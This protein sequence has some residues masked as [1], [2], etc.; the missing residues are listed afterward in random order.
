MLRRGKNHLSDFLKKWGW[1]YGHDARFSK[2]LCSKLKLQ[3][4]E[5]WFCRWKN[6]DKKDIY[7]FLSLENP[8]FFASTFLL[9]K[10]KTWKRFFVTSSESSQNHAEKQFM[11]PKTTVIWLFSEIRCY[12]VTGWFD[13]KI[14]VFQQTFICKGLLHP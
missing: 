7:I 4:T 10:E 11:P 14:G 5:T 13:W 3:K 12:L 8:Y 2:N 1:F 6:T 9:V